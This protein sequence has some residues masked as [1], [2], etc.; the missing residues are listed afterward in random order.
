MV[1]RDMDELEKVF[2]PEDYES[3]R[4]AKLSLRELAREDAN[5]MLEKVMKEIGMK[6]SNRV[7]ETCPECGGSIMREEVDVG[8]GTLRGPACCERCGWSE[9]KE[10]NKVLKMVTKEVRDVSEG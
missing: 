7:E 6:K 10:A 5:R 1:Y 8:V 9:E 3:K 2:F 4:R